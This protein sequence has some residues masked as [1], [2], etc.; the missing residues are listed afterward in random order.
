MVLG[1]VVLGRMVFGQMVFL[2]L[3]EGLLTELSTSVRDLGEQ[4]FEFW[5]LNFELWISYRCRNWAIKA[6]IA[7][8]S[9]SGASSRAVSASEM[10]SSRRPNCW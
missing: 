7:G 5:I 2:K 4:D 10:A 1:L 9:L 6:S 3:G 8:L